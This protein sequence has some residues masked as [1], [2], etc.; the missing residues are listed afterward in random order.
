VFVF[1]RASDSLDPVNA[2]MA[3]RA[4]Q[5]AAYVFTNLPAKA[6]ELLE[7]MAQPAPAQPAS[8]TQP[9]GEGKG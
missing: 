3:K 5:L 4:F 9:G 7:T 8:V 1:L 2:L 6:E